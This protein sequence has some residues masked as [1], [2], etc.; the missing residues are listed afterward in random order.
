MTDSDRCVN[1]LSV[2]Q[3]CTCSFICYSCAF[4]A[5]G[6]LQCTRCKIARYCNLDCQKSNWNDHRN[7]CSA[8][9]T[10]PEQFQLDYSIQ[11][12]LYTCTETALMLLLT[13]YE[14]FLF[15]SELDRFC[16]ELSANP[17]GDICGYQRNNVAY[18]LILYSCVQ[19]HRSL[20][21]DVLPLK[22]CFCL[23]EFIDGWRIVQ[24]YKVDTIFVPLEVKK[25]NILDLTSQVGTLA[26]SDIWMKYISRKADIT[27]QWHGSTQCGW[28]SIYIHDQNK[29]ALSDLK[30]L[31]DWTQ[32]YTLIR[33]ENDTFNVVRK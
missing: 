33:R 11:R 3:D 20:P 24:S 9:I 29:F 30:K 15:N 13:R 7:S 23:V 2:S 12:T 14:E 31:T 25:F 8:S 32:K 6:H 10:K 27:D 16:Q 19:D 22:H 5:S 17:Y 18:R 4:R 21:P 1:C 28:A 26:T